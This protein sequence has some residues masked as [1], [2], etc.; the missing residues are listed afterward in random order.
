M[1]AVDPRD[2][3]IAALEAE[4][5]ELREQLRL[6]QGLVQMGLKRIGDLEGQIQELQAALRRN[7]TNSS[8]P[9]SSDPPSVERPAKEPT[10][11]KPGGQPGHEPHQRR[12]VPPEK[13]DHTVV[14]KPERCG[15]CQRPLRGEDP[16]PRRHQVVEV[17]A[18]KPTVTDYWLHELACDCGHPTRAPLPPG[19][20]PSP[21]G[22]RL[23]ALIA[24][25]TGQYRL[26]KRAVEGL[27]GDFFG[28]KISLGGICAV[29]QF[30]SQ[31]IAEPVAEAR[32]FVRAAP[33]AH[34]DE[35]SWRERRQKA[36]LWVAATAK[37]A[38]FSIARRRGTAVAKR[39]LGAF[40]GILVSDRWCAYEWVSSARRQLCWA[41][42]VRTLQ[43]FVDQRGAGSHLA[44]VL[45]DEIDRMF[46]WWHRIRDGTLSRTT[47]RKYMVAVQRSVRD[48]LGAGTVSR[49]RK[50]RGLCRDLLRLEPA[51]WTF[52]RVPGVE[53]TN[54][55]GERVIRHAVLWRRGSFGTHSRAG[56]RFVERIMSVVLTLRLQER[57][58]LDYL[59]ASCQAHLRDRPAPS[60]VPP[61]KHDLAQ[62]A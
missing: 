26:S 43:G 58:V 61:L 57:N 38:V 52:V 60:L 49:A 54:N 56:S 42:L 46:T 2:Q 11:K 37:V 29:E 62:A 50:F 53:P 45:L 51:L 14:L 41:H 1:G 16:A 7:S 47:F 25:C 59:T 23:S 18:L 3:R 33:V 19:L 36:W 4:N 31:A 40:R 39:L 34:A 15:R 6:G 21:F 35:T 20:S 27:L 30:V 28:L 48:L 22:P 24:V 12:L 17:P 5:R 13:V 44:Q 10:G 32:A 8:R 9:P 55:H